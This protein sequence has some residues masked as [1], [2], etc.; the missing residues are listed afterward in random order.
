MIVVTL[1]HDESQ[2]EAS[3]PEVILAELQGEV[4][5]QL[6]KVNVD[7]D[8]ALQ[9]VYKEHLPVIEVGPYILREPYITRQDI[10]VA[11]MSA[12]DRKSDLERIGDKDYL[13]RV[14]KSKQFSGADRFSYWF[15][16][17]YMLLFN[18]IVFIYVGLPFL[19]PVL[20]KVGAPTPAKIIYS[21]YSPL[22]HQL[23]FRSWFLFGEQSVYP[24]ELANLDGLKT[25]EEISGGQEV[26]II[27]AREFIGN[28]EIGYKVAF[29]ERDIAIYAGILLFGIVFAVSGRKIRAL[30][31]YLWIALGIIPIGL[32]GVSQL[33]GLVK[34]FLP[35]WLLFIERESTPFLRTLTGGLFGIT[36]A[37][38][39]YPM[40]EET[41][42]DTRRVLMRKKAVFEQVNSG[43]E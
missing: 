5:H 2:K 8:P 27:D 22:C 24:R 15:S 39:L 7:D 14:E 1:Y 30:P 31:W 34:E 43:K 16:M 12:R 19:A 18:L 35:T 42:Q 20:M 40:I 10:L 4:P 38:Y 21:I 41:M 13:R 32:D 29:C 33:P 17:R 6:V 3:F 9:K 26:N 37:W 11:L 36:T 28:E 25:Y 23:A